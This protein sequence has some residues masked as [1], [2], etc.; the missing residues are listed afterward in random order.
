MVD[1]D[2]LKQAGTTNE[3]LR[4][5]LTSVRPA[6]YKKLT[7][8]EQ[9]KI[10]RDTK[11]RDKIEKL[12]NSRLREHI[13]FTLRNHHIYSA[14]DLAW[15]AAPI[16]KQTIPL[17][18]Y[19]QKRLSLDSCVSELD[20]L[21]VT[22]KFV[23]KSEAGQPTEIDLPK[24]FETNINLVRSLITRRLS[25]QSNKYNNLYPFFKYSPRST[26]PTAK[27]KGDVLSQRIDIMADQYDYRH[28]QTQCIRDMMLYGHSVAFPRASWER[29]VQWQRKNLSEEF[30]SEEIE[31]E[32]RVMKEG[33]SWINPHPSR[34]FWDINH[35]LNS[36]NSDSGA[37]YIGYWEVLKYKD[38]ADNPAF[39]NRSRVSYRGS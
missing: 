27:L 31:K 12:I 10:D 22:D 28:F 14:V 30:R 20:K 35:P 7:K 39:F 18:M 1:L 11:N 4:E 23:R 33:L 25:A 2:I 15:D 9:G 6:D 26:T 5:V 38:V 3:R 36:I 13:V 34:V 29:E 8:E 17:I 32:A 21:K 24:F 19:A 16:S 37:E